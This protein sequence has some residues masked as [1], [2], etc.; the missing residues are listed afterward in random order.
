MGTPWG[1]YLVWL[2]FIGEYIG[3]WLGNPILG[4]NE[5]GW[6]STQEF[7]ITNISSDVTIECLSV[8]WFSLMGAPIGFDLSISMDGMLKHQVPIG[9]VNHDELNDL[10]DPTPRQ[11]STAHAVSLW[12]TLQMSHSL[13][14]RLPEDISATS[15]KAQIAIELFNYLK[16]PVTTATQEARRTILDLLIEYNSENPPKKECLIVKE[17]HL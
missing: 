6:L 8:G 13:R 7:Q 10:P 17:K 15:I 9:S 12:N 3:S 2:G 11:P 4:D 16:P 14:P 5:V 1:L